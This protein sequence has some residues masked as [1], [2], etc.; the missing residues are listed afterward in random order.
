MEL[1]GFF[2]E[3]SEEKIHA[4]GHPISREL[5][6]KGYTQKNN[7]NGVPRWY[8][9]PNKVWVV[10]EIN[11]ERQK[12]NI[13]DNIMAISP[14]RE[15]MPLKLAQD[16]ICAILSGNIELVLRDSKPYLIRRDLS[17]VKH[18]KYTT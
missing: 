7:S 4:N 1:L 9:K 18:R 5:L 8:V 2:Y 3:K 10:L 14:G 17:K 13:Y 11:G 6:K 12:F 16:T 15:R